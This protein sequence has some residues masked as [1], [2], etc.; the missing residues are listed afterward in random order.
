MRIMSVGVRGVLRGYPLPPS[1]LDWVSYSR[2]YDIYR[3]RERDYHRLYGS[4]GGTPVD[5]A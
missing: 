5:M 2:I 4:V 3:M 1:N